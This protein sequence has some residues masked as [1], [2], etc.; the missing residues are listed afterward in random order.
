MGVSSASR[1]RDA[2]ANKKKILLRPCRNL[3]L[4]DPIHSVVT[5]LTEL[6]SY[7]VCIIG[8]FN[9]HDISDLISSPD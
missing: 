6:P 1:L 7:V 5:I 3:K 2:V 8:L 4:G 9:R